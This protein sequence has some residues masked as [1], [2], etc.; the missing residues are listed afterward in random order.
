MAAP[1]SSPSPSSPSPEPAALPPLWSDRDYR[2]WWTANTVSALGTSMSAIAYP[3]LVLYSTGSV[4]SA[5]AITAAQLVG[6]LVTTLYGGALADRV[7]RK[8]ILVVA[9]LVQAAALA[10][11][12]VLVGAGSPALVVLMACAL[13]SGAAA[14]FGA[15][16]TNPALR[17]IVPKE[18]LG[19]AASQELG[20]DA[21]ADLLGAPL[22]GLLFSA[23]RWIP[24]AADAASFLVASLGA[25]L[26]RRPLGPDAA[27]DRASV[28]ADI[29]AG[30]ALVRRERFLRFVVVWGSLLN[31]VAQGFALLFI[32]LVRHRGGSPATVGF[33]SSLAL[34]GGI[35]GAVI[36]P[37]LLRTVR[38]RLV[39]HVSAWA[40][41]ASFAAVALVPQ[42]W[43]IGAVMLVAML[44][45][46]P[47]NVVLEAYL[48]R[49]VP[50]EF[51]GRVSA[52][53]R[54]GGQA[55]QWSGPL[56][57]GLLAAVLGVPG[58]AL[59]LMALTVPLALALH[60]T[61][62]LD[63]LDLPLEQVEEIPVPQPEPAQ[64]QRA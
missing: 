1:T 24:F 9:P 37:A 27:G 46:V 13:V 5:G 25:A 52:V 42:P 23:A 60:L 20:R 34:I 48:V 3:L 11:V 30:F 51:S 18:Q 21:A 15:G 8:A 39:L 14:G 26:I 41:V 29:R 40:F 45:M 32:A 61:R 6:T 2:G 58:G 59:A 50:D 31:V 10:A 63:V 56:L 17:R 49:L 19:T 7:S 44:F 35:A 57:A 12:A 43:Q 64:G 33:V 53:T 54:F 4:A 22:G 28:L 16:A 55:L 36:A 62:S 38:A 47:L